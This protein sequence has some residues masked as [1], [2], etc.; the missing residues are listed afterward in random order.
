MT[1]ETART[2]AAE[3]KLC[4]NGLAQA[5]VESAQQLND[6]EQKISLGLYQLLA[7]GS[8]VPVG[9]LA[10]STGIDVAGISRV[11]NSWPGVYFDDSGKVIGFWG[12][13]IKPMR[14]QLI[15]GGKTLYT[16]CAWDGLFIPELLKTSATL[17]TQCPV[18][19]TRLSVFV[20]DQVN[21][22][23]PTPEIVMSFI[24]PKQGLFDQD[25]IGQF[26]DYIYFFQ[27]RETAR[28]WR[29]SN[30]N[31]LLLDLPQA[32]E[33]GRLKNQKQFGSLI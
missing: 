16:W 2:Q 6:Q 9:K 17:N 13:T 20:D 19:K 4:V 31:I 26:C 18:S 1:R 27:D 7:I 24:E 28:Q 30:P 32:M 10:E 22:E 11:L 15:L 5:F 8:P 23:T 33:L 21:F 12:L 25:I 29:G 3:V 14:H